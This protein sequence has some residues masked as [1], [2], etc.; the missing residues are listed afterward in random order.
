MLS[1]SLLT[2][3]SLPYLLAELFK[4]D[5]GTGFDAAKR[6]EEENQASLFTILHV[7]SVWTGV[8]DRDALRQ[9]MGTRET[10][11]NTINRVT[12]T[13]LVPAESRQIRS[14]T[15]MSREWPT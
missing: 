9:L 14:S 6:L 13:G 3:A 15:H 5:K 2:L 10:H 7:S 4:R 1:S 8:A 12:R 11:S